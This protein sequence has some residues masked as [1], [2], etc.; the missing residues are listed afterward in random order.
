[1]DPH[2]LVEDVMVTS[3]S[4]SMKPFTINTRKRGHW[5]ATHLGNGLY[6]L[7]T[8]FITLIIH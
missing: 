8:L 3:K 7:E 2:F 4:L 5:E 1:M 6:S